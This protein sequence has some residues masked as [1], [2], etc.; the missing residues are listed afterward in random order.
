MYR[1]G[2]GEQILKLQAVHFDVG[3][4]ARHRDGQEVGPALEPHLGLILKL[5]VH[6]YLRRIF[7]IFLW[8]IRNVL[9]FYVYTVDPKRF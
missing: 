2:N 9:H 3:F 6:A 5:R 7:L 1:P 8:P 4:D